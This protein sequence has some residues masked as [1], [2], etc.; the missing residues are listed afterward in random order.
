M[1][2][3]HQQ[4]INEMIQLI[5]KHQDDPE[6]LRELVADFNTFL[7]SQG[8]PDI[9]QQLIIGDEM[10]QRVKLEMKRAED[11]WQSKGV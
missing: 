4:T 5:L 8:L 10:K 3:P 1:N 2:N 9:R 11:E 7:E 6:I